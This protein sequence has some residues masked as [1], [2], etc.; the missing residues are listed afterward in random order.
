ME[1][2]YIIKKKTR[3]DFADRRL[4]RGIKEDFQLDFHSP[5]GCSK[6]AGDQYVH[7]YARIYGLRTLVFRQSCIYGDFQFGNADQGWVAHFMRKLLRGKTITIYG[8]G[9]QVR[10][11]LYVRDLVDCYVRAIA[12]ISKTSGRVYNIGGG[13]RYSVSL[14]E[15]LPLLERECKAVAKIRF[16][17]WRPGDQR[18][19]ITD[20]S[21]AGQDFG[22]KPTTPIGRGLN[23]LHQWMTTSHAQSSMI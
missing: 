2:A 9:K 7:D 3:Y 1:N 20:Y 23:N 11:L 5:Y 16:S 12:K 14:I 21:M 13:R 22:W 19:Y 6:G 17:Q 8:D 18:V 4:R 10:D 15:L